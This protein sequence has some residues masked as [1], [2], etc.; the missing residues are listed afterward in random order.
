MKKVVIIILLGFLLTGNI[1]S[2]T[3]ENPVAFLSLS[4]QAMDPRYDYLE[5]IIS[6]ILL[7]DLSNTQGVGVVDHSNM[8]R[9]MDEQ[10]LHLTGLLEDQSEAIEFGKI[11]GARYLLKGGFI[12]LGAEVLVNLS[13]IDVETAKTSVFSDRGST[14]NL[15][16]RLAEKIILRITGREVVLHSD[17]QRRS[18]ISLRDET[19]GSIA[20]HCNLWNAEI[21]V[22]GVFAGYTPDDKKIPFELEDLSPGNHT[23]RIYMA[24]FGVARMPEI[25]FYDWEE[26]ILVKSGKRF[27]IR[28][29]I[30]NINSLKYYYR[31]LL[32]ESIRVRK[33]DP[34][35]IIREDNISFVDREG[36]D[37][38][39]F[40]KLEFQLL[41][42]DFKALMTVTYNDSVTIIELAGISGKN[43][44]IKETIGKIDF[45]LRIDNRY[46]YRYEVSYSAWRND[47]NL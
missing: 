40:T 11:M 2:Q 29:D 24:G 42:D 28:A 3:A 10:K 19:P 7:Y 9:I 16:H 6:G 33:D 23:I 25:E 26:T 20:L 14:E 36:R 17:D 35:E 32:H 45:S 1:Y 30:G 21:F 27:V 4:N 47:I 41:E 44:E 31:K 13:L 43:V 34:E 37:L 8:N 39:V 5:G 46:E 22:D 38:S 15:V 18:I 12:F